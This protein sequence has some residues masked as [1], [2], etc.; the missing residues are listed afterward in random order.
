M[1]SPIAKKPVLLLLFILGCGLL[2]FY[3]FKKKNQ[4][5]STQMT[6]PEK[7]EVPSLTK[8]RPE[9]VIE[10]I[11]YTVSYN[12][13]WC[14]PNWVAYELTD[15]ESEGTEERAKHFEP[16]PDVKGFCPS[17]KDYSNSGYDR[18]HMAPAGD[19]KWSR[20]AM[21]ESFYLS[22]ICPQN[23]NLNSGDWKSLE[24][25][26]RSW[27][28]EFQNVYVTCG[29]IVSAHSA[30]I[31][32]HNITVPDA[33]FKVILCRN[34]DQWQSIGFCFENKAGHKPLNTYCKTVDEIE[35]ITG[36]DFFPLLEDSIENV[37][38]ATYNTYFWGL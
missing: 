30:T 17:S 16:D 4:P 19:M 18:G 26:V 3:S 7:L 23:H 6:V 13:D 11:G 21:R 38:E 34:G 27:A 2:L 8:P 12:P 33:F 22:N 24:E 5:D 28:K 1:K 9:Q 36:I 14:I 25:K 31:G 35:E 37:V 15:A 29:P 10:H 20:Q 32:E